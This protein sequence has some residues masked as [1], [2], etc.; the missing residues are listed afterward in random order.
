[1]NSMDQGFLDTELYCLV[2]LS[3]PRHFNSK[4]AGSN[5]FTAGQLTLGS[6]IPEN[7]VYCSCINN[8]K[9]ER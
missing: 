5:R 7:N 4:V 2:R 9:D 8:K 3:T 6:P 1:M